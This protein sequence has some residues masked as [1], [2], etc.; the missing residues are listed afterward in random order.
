MPSASLLTT[1]VR[2]VLIY[3]SC[4]VEIYFICKFDIYLT[5]GFEIEVSGFDINKICRLDLNIVCRTIVSRFGEL[6]EVSARID[7][8]LLHHI[9][10]Q[11]DCR[12]VTSDSKTTHTPHP[13]SSGML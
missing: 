11:G 12:Q 2:Y 9:L 10:P 3:V 6:E 8:A 1:Q 13:S 4:A 5:C 7:Q